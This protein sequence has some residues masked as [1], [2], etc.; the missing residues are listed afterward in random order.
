MWLVDEMYRHSSTIQT[1]SEAWQEFF[2]DYKPHSRNS[3]PR[4]KTASPRRPRSNQPGRDPGNPG[5]NPR[6]SSLKRQASTR[7]PTSLE[8]QTSNRRT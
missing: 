3:R 6:F 4:L 7:G 2:E 1:V 5:A 8:P